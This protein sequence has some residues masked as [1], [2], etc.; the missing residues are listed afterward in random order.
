MSGGANIA[1]LSIAVRSPL[2]S[3][4]LA[5]AIVRYLR[6]CVASCQAG[7]THR[8]LTF[9]RGL[10][11]RTGTDCRSTRGGC[12]GFMSTGR[13]VVLLD[14]HTR[15][16]HLR[17]RVGLTCRM[18]ARISRRLRV[19]ETG[20][21]RVAPMCA[22]IRPTAMPL[23]PTGPGGLVVLVNFVFLTNINDIK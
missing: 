17:G 12:T 8:S 23:G 18:C 4:S 19:T 14:C 1:A 10:C 16:R 20:I 21:R 6:G 13:G 3:T 22:I 9:A 11:K 15:R 2:V 7:G 5:S